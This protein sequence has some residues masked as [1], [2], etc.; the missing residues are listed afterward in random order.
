MSEALFDTDKFLNSC[1]TRKPVDEG[2]WVTTHSISGR[3]VRH[4]KSSVMGST[5][6]YIIKLKGPLLIQPYLT[7]MRWKD[8]NSGKI[9]HNIFR[10]DDSLESSIAYAS[11]R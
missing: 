8:G 7:V 3:L 9:R 6:Y 5:D 10:Y 1:R 4:I 2:Q 11:K